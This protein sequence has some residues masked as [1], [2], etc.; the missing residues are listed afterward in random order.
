MIDPWWLVLGLA[1]PFVLGACGA[2]APTRLVGHQLGW[3]VGL[4]VAMGVG[5]VARSGW[6]RMPP[7]Q[8][9][10]WLAVVGLPAIALAAVLAGRMRLQPGMAWVVRAGVAVVLPPMLLQSYLRYHWSLGEAAAWLAGL[11][12]VGLLGWWATLRSLRSPGVSGGEATPAVLGVTAGA[13]A[14]VTLLTYSLTQAQWSATLAAALLGGGLVTLAWR[15]RAGL[16]AAVDVG[17]PLTLA[18]VLLGRLYG[19]GM[20]NLHAGLLVAGP[21]LATVAHWPGGRWLLGMPGWRLALVRVAAAA[22]AAGLAV[23]IAAVQWFAA[24]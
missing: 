12:A 11:S 15:R 23:V 16:T 20:T 18:M 7:N 8:A 17:L 1:L 9:H 3:V 5:Y 13:A 24:R 21:L 19:P 2:L 4:T 14:M 6:P 22:V 10:Q